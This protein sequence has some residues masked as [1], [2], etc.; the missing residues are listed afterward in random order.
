MVP[1]NGATLSGGFA[2]WTFR[3]CG[4][5]NG[6]ART[7]RSASL[8]EQRA[9]ELPVLFVVSG[10]YERL[11]VSSVFSLPCRSQIPA[12]RIS[13]RLVSARTVQVP[14]LR[15]FNDFQIE[16]HGRPFPGR[17][18]ALAIVQLWDAG[19]AVAEVE[20]THAQGIHGISFAFP[21]QFGYPHI[22]DPHWDPL[23]RVCEET[24]LSVNLHIG[25]GEA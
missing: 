1:S 20:R 16:A 3:E 11:E 8:V 12:R 25:S 21:Q 22:A 9:F 19:T 14:D 5:T 4:P 6:L 2:G 23:W 7:V 18:I 24:G 10:A 13:N 15:A 17:F